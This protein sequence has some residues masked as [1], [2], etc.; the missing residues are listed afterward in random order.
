MG[1][2]SEPLSG[3]A[4]DGQLAA[5]VDAMEGANVGEPAEGMGGMVH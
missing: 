4:W 5:L 3:T 2:Y 1:E